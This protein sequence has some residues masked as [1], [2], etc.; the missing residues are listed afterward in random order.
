MVRTARQW[1][2][3]DRDRADAQ[4]LHRA[5]A[6][7]RDHPDRAGYAGVSDNGTAAA[8][9]AL[10]DILAAGITHLDAGV[11]WQ[12]LEGARVVLGETMA[13]P[14]RRRTRRH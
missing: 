14:D 6:W 5:A 4:L 7:L 2:Q 3:Y 8:L 1:R 11:R 12:A 9:A 13:D 10:L